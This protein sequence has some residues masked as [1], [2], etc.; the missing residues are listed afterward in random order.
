MKKKI[1]DALKTKFSGVSEVILDRIATKKAENVTD[2][3][4]ITAI[5]DGISFQDVVTSYGDYRANE[6]NISSVN[7]YEEKYGLKDGKPVTNNVEE[8]TPAAGGKNT[9]TVDELDSYFNS[10]LEAAI[11]PYKEKI[12]TFEVEKQKGTRQAII[13]GK[14]KELGLTDDDMKFVIVPENKDPSEFL[15]GYKQHLITQGLKPAETD[16]GAQV[17]DLQVQNAVADDWMSSIVAPESKV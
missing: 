8:P 6:A 9:F 16:G 17:S 7:N 10:K 11:K 15:T 1:L 14:M 13:A 3:N 5:V 4:Q 12:E 2:E